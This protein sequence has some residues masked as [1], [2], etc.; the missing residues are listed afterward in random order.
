MLSLTSIMDFGPTQ[1]M[2]VP[3][4]PLSLST[5]SLSR[6]DGSTLGIGLYECTCSALGGE[7]LSHSLIT[8]I[9]PRMSS[10]AHS[11]S[12]LAR[13]VRKRLNRRKKDCI[14][15]S[16]ICSRRELQAHY[17]SLQPLTFFFAGSVTPETIRFNSF[18]IVL[19]ATPVVADLKSYHCHRQQT[20][21][22]YHINIASRT[23][24]ISNVS[25]TPSRT[26]SQANHSRSAP[27]A[28]GRLHILSDWFR[29]SGHR[30]QLLRT[31]KAVESLE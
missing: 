14:S 13:S 12:P 21:I 16:K 10:T 5:A 8:S 23:K 7:I 3:R 29:K 20:N 6:M 4:P 1:P 15:A 9:K 24:G 28:S 30:N 27:L 22:M 11:F 19:A 2:V 25:Q 18:R 31:N 26:R 17:P